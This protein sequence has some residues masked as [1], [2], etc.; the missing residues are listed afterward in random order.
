MVIFR[1][2]GPLQPWFDKTWKLNDIEA[3]SPGAKADFYF[4]FLRR[5]ADRFDGEAEAGREQLGRCD[6][7]G[8]PSPVERCAFCRLVERAGGAVPVNAPT[9]RGAK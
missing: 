7:C 3:A 2:Y 5:A 8:A 9:L 4:G 6:T 1:L